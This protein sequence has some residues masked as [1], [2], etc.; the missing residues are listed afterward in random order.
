[1]RPQAPNESKNPNSFEGSRSKTEKKEKGEEK[2]LGTFEEI[3]A[4]DDCF[5]ILRNC[6][7]TLCQIGKV[8]TQS[9]CPTRSFNL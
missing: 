9:L 3:D 2:R 7:L 1:M 8:P 4:R 5:V 6:S